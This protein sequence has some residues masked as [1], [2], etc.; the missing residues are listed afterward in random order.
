[1]AAAN[2]AD[3]DREQ[4]LE[5]YQ[6]FIL[7]TASLVLKRYVTQSDDAWSVAL[8]A[9][10]EAVNQYNAAKGNFEVYAQTVIRRR[11]IDDQRKQKKFKAEIDV[12]PEV[13]TGETDQEDA[14]AAQSQQ[15]ILKQ[16]CA[17]GENSIQDEVA[18]LTCLLIPYGFSF[19]DLTACSPKSTKT[20]SACSLAAKHMLNSRELVLKMR[21]S[22]RLPVQ[23]IAEGTG[24]DWKVI[25]RHRRYIITVVEILT[26]DYPVLQTY[27]ET[28]QR[29]VSA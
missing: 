16:A 27:L 2:R 7:K 28:I 11:M 14:T 21:E 25:D 24:V 17:P 20:K 29:G 13:F 5:A 26:G 6:P 19:M 4:M 3:G 12:A 22:H 18:D 9:F 23:A 8:I 15:A 1:M 10:W